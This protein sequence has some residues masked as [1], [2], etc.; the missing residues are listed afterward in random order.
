MIKQILFKP[1]LQDSFIY[2]FFSFGREIFN[3][4]FK[5]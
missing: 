5:I 2:C 4:F 3:N 1:L